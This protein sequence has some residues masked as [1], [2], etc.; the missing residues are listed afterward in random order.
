MSRRIRLG[1]AVIMVSGVLAVAP[2]GAGAAPD[3]TGEAAATE[4]ASATTHTTTVRWGPFDVPAMGTTENLI[5]KPGG[6]SW[7]V[8]FFTD[9][10]D[11]QIEKPCEDCYITKMIPNLVEAGTDTPVNFDNQG[12]LHH[13]VN[14]NWSRP[15]VT[16]RPSWFGDT[17]NLLGAV[18]G[19]NER[20]FASGNERTV[21]EVPDGYG[22]RVRPG[23]QWGLIVDVMNMS[24]QDRQYEFEYTFEWVESAEPVRP[25]WLDIDQ[26]S[27]SEVDTPAGYS[28]HHYDWRSTLDGRIVA[29]GGHLHDQGIAISAENATTG[30]TICT[31][32]AA[33]VDGGVGE[34]AGPGT[35]ADDMHPA[36]WVT[37]TESWNPEVSFES[38]QGHISGHVTCQ[39]FT[40]IRDPWWRRGDLIR[41]HATYNHDQPTH[42][43]M[44]IMVAYVDED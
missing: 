30:E 32:R 39:P 8:G 4:V 41:V 18:E 1:L 6:C 35:G 36:D 29:I 5:A 11:M 16:C 27:D 34:P 25:V 38:Y 40:R 20:F 31:S 19:G 12:M 42:G 17:I 13:V 10:V 44:G 22:F 21:M 43:D 37:Q 9:C 24:M 14:V 3:S 33:Y 28:D 26:C 2:S 7:L 23:D 15:D